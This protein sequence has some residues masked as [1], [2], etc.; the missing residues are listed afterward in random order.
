MKSLKDRLFGSH[1]DAVSEHLPDDRHIQ[2]DAGD[3]EN[4]VKLGKGMEPG[5]AVSSNSG[6]GGGTGNGKNDDDGDGNDEARNRAAVS[7][8]F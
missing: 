8:P 3:V 4:W 2:D 5:H 7:V 1:G 6:S